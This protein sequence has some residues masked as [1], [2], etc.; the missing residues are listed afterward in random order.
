[1]FNC[2]KTSITKLLKLGQSRIA[3]YRQS[4]RHNNRGWNT[5]KS[6]FL[7][8]LEYMYLK[9]YLKAVAG[10][11]SSLTSLLPASFIEPN[12]SL[13]YF[14]ENFAENNKSEWTFQMSVW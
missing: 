14:H 1:M 9:R 12:S 10:V 4:S 8:E 13:D 6:S 5:C 7:T 2:V 11:S 3:L